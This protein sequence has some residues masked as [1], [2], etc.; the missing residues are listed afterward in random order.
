MTLAGLGH[1]VAHDGGH[2]GDRLTLDAVDPGRRHADETGLL[3]A[4]VPVGPQDHLS[5]GVEDRELVADRRHREVDAPP[6][7]LHDDRCRLTGAGAQGRGHVGGARDGPP[8]DGDEDVARLEARGGCRGE[9]VGRRAW[10]GRL[11]AGGPHALL[12]RA[13]AGT[14]VDL[15]AVEGHDAPD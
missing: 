5:V 6:A 10:G 12:D 2:R 13:D 8:G 15:G 7:A 1:A 3:E 14:A 4:R 11:G 9:L